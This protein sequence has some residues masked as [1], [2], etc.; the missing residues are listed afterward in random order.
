LGD[1]LIEIACIPSIYLLYFSGNKTMSHQFETGF[2][3]SNLPAWHGL[4]TILEN[5]PTFAGQLN[6]TLR[7]FLKA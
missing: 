4:G 1:L 6:K 7:S 2:F 3:A 5:P